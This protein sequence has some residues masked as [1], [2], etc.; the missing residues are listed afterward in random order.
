MGCL[1]RTA[2]KGIAWADREAYLGLRSRDVSRPVHLN[3]SASGPRQPSL[4]R[5]TPLLVLVALVAVGTSGAFGRGLAPRGGGSGE[6]SPEQRV[7]R[8]LHD[9]YTRIARP[10]RAVKP[11]L[12]APPRVVATGAR[13][14]STEV[15]S[16]TSG[17]DAPWPLARLI[18]TRLD[19]PPPS[20]PVG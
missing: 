11:R 18:V 6:Q 4:L 10:L 20:A 8:T 3:S 9:A 13:A 17:G 16:I 5:G 2:P 1:A 14:G 7:T 19:L 15:D 12:V